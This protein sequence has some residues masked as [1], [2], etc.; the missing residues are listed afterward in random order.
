MSQNL[1]PDLVGEKVLDMGAD[2]TEA[3]VAK[4]TDPVILPQPYSSPADFAA[5]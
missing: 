2:G 4:T 1:T 3:F 5:Q